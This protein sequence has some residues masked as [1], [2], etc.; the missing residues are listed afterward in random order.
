MED[1]HQFFSGFAII[2]KEASHYA[3]DH[4]GVIV[5]NSPPGHALMLSSNDDSK[6]LRLNEL[7][8]GVS[9]HDGGFFLDLGSSHHPFNESIE[10]AETDNAITWFDTDPTMTSDGDK[11]MGAGGPN[12][13]GSNGIDLVKLLD[14][15][16]IGDLRGFEV[17]PLK[18]LANI[19]P[20]NTLGGFPS[21]VVIG[22]ID[23]ES[24]EEVLDPILNLVLDLF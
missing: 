7:L 10:L 20:S 3:S 12:G 22:C 11:V 24:I 6:T 16:E 2:T 23:D 5:T 18:D 21:V 15:G 13:D 14:I 17:S 4:F 19:H 1:V 9:E 8:N